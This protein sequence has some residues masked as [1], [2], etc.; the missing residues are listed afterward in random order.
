M[1]PLINASYINNFASLSALLAVC[2]SIYLSPLY[3]AN[4][5]L[6]LLR[7]NSNAAGGK[8]TGIP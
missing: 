8:S 1:L 5:L 2:L 4:A 6:A 7:I 3:M